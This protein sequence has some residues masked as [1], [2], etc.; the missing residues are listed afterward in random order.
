MNFS[1]VRIVWNPCYE[2]FTLQTLQY[3]VEVN[4][5]YKVDTFLNHN[6]TAFDSQR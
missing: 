1:V 5:H 6:L 4:G 2:C 3:N